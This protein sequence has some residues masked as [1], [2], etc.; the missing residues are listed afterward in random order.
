MQELTQQIHESPPRPTRRRSPLP[1]LL[2]AALLGLGTALGCGAAAPV[3]PLDNADS[4]QKNLTPMCISATQGDPT[5]CKD[6]KTW[7]AYAAMD[8]AGKGLVLS[9]VSFA[10]S[11][12]VGLYRQTTYDCCSTTP[13]P[14][15]PMCMWTPAPAGPAVCQKDDA[16]KKEGLA[17]CA[18]H[19]LVLNDLK[20]DH[21]CIAGGYGTAQYEC[22][23]TTPTPP[24]TPMC[25][26]Q[27]LTEKSCVDDGT[28]KTRA[29]AACKAKMQTLGSVTLGKSC[30]G[31][32]LDIQFQCCGPVTPPP[33]PP[34]CT[35]EALASMT[36]VDDTT[37]KLKADATCTAKKQT[38]GT[39]AFGTACMGGHTD[40]KFE[41]CG[42]VT[43]PPPPPMC[44]GEEL[45]SMTCVDDGT[46]KTRA[47]ATCAAKKQTLGSIAFGTACMGGHQNIKF[48]CCGPVTP[49]P[50]PP[51]CSTETL[52]SMSCVDDG[53]WKLKADGVCTAKKQTLSSLSFGAACMG[54]HTEVKFECCGPVVMPPP[55][56]TTDKAPSTGTC[57]TPDNW[58]RAGDTYCT[59]KHQALSGLS[60]SGACAGGF[61]EAQFQCCGPVTPPPP[62]PTCTGGLVGDGRSCVTEA[63]LKSQA[64]A[65][66]KMAGTRL[67]AFGAFDAC[68]MM[69]QYLQAKYECCK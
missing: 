58:K 57:Q 38:L 55:M 47:A 54:G 21:P 45:A 35:G 9:K 32:H 4:V 26:T 5:S 52:A 20:L 6:E 67:T 30:M 17:F 69:G 36:C 48:E 60:L 16:W 18:M 64:E 44:S 24:P 39:L 42:A 12:G 66:C 15:T 22:C 61:S 68:G 13:M 27:A 2:W 23:T 49:P 3:E 29:E 50:P 53:T 1:A 62:P 25:T 46:W 31:G 33:P 65:I 14:P 8:C 63:N 34:M 19:G 41:C 28:W 10:T 51:M 40:I 7:S 59:A 37:W 11:C 56:C 43:P